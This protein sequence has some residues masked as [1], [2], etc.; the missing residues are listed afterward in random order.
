MDRTP[1][2]GDIYKQNRDKI[3]GFSHIVMVVGIC[4]GMYLLGDGVGYMA[5]QLNDPEQWILLKEGVAL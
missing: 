1:R 5:E 3:D 4:E 2:I